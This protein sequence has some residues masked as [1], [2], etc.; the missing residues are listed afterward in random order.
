MNRSHAASNLH[1]RSLWNTMKLE[2][3]ISSKRCHPSTYLHG[4]ILQ[5]TGIIFYNVHKL[6]EHSALRS[7]GEG[8]CLLLNSCSSAVRR[9]NPYH[10]T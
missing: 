6:R 5:K 3:I 10:K 1:P 2:T 8:K 7:V 4:I 9:E